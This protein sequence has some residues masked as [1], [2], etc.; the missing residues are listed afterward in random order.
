MWLFPFLMACSRGVCSWWLTALQSALTDREINDGVFCLRS[1]D[2]RLLLSGPGG[3]WFST[4]VTH[5]LSCFFL[6]NLCSEQYYIFC[7]IEH[8]FITRC[9]QKLT[10]PVLAKTSQVCFRFFPTW[11]NPEWML[12]DVVQK[13]EA[14]TPLCIFN[15]SYNNGKSQRENW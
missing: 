7:A 6:A 2:S 8:E 3:M 5:V 11:K 1:A 14:A 13:S 4:S 15:W 9:I 12:L 10:C